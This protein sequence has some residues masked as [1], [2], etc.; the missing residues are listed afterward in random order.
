M[1]LPHDVISLR[2][3]VFPQPPESQ[4]EKALFNEDL[5]K[6][7]PHGPPALHI[8]N[9]WSSLYYLSQ[10]SRYN[11][12]TRLSSNYYC[13]GSKSTLLNPCVYTW[14]SF[15]YS[16]WKSRKSCMP[17]LS[18]I[19]QVTWNTTCL[20]SVAFIYLSNYILIIS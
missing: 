14:N 4:T 6:P 19:S 11:S 15:F 2:I 16:I 12:D 7:K 1:F 20:C 18:T 17:L 13:T 10:L 5:H 8:V 3:C 9:L